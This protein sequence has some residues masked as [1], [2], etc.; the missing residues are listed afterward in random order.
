M[1]NLASYKSDYP[2]YPGE[3]TPLPETTARLNRLQLSKKD[4]PLNPLL[5]IDEFEECYKIIAVIPGV[6]REDIFISVHDNILSIIVLHRDVEVYSKKYKIHEFEGKYF[7]RDIILPGNADPAFVSSE[8][9]AGILRICISKSEFPIK[10]FSS[11]IV[12]Y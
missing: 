2:A 8:Y 11:H 1:N 10:F 12:T 9:H 7:E 6:S 3:Y 5:N 4:F